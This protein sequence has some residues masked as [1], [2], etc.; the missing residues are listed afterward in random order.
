MITKQKRIEE[1]LSIL[2]SI[3][4]PNEQLNDR[5][6]VTL[7]ALLDMSLNKDWLQVTNPMLT[8]RG[9]LDFAR[10]KMKMRYA[11]NTRESIRKYSVKQLVEAGV[12]LHNPDDP[13]RPV[14]SALNCYQVTDLA[15]ELFRKFGTNK[16]QRALLSYI[17]LKPKLVDSFAKKREMIRLSVKILNGTN[18]KLSPGIHSKLIK[19]IIEEFAE[20]FV[21]GAELVYIGDTG[22]KWGYYNSQ[23]LKS[24]GV[25]V[26]VHGKMPDVIIYSR[27]RN[28][29]F[30]VEAVA[31]SGP[32]DGLRHKELTNLFKG[33]KAGLVYITAFPDRGKLM[34][35]FLSVVAWETDVWCASDPT[36]L[37]H[38]NG[39]RFLGPY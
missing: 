38:F 29:L 37:I 7:L 1:A 2:K 34:K 32:V 4:M 21:P 26:E 24:L 3:G 35:K 30:L 28:W 33:S 20:R 23:L 9:I 17:K 5:T 25:N 14:N 16:W 6:A 8:I 39:S 10:T 22:K 11:E 15:L 13:K 27:K 36:H 18:I 19:Q 12:L 31:S